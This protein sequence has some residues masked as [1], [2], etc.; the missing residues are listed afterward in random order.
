MISIRTSRIF[1]GVAAALV[2][3]SLV[4]VA[5]SGARADGLS[6]TFGNGGN[7]QFDGGGFAVGQG[8]G[9]EGLPLP[10]K[11]RQSDDDEGLPLP[12]IVPHVQV[13]VVIAG[14]TDPCERIVHVGPSGP[15][16]EDQ[17]VREM[18]TALGYK[19][20]LPRARFALLTLWLAHV[21]LQKHYKFMDKVKEDKTC[22]MSQYGDERERDIRKEI[23]YW[24]D[25]VRGYYHG[26][27]K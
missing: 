22:G 6:L 17:A 5:I 7:M 20:V 23:K 21:D 8:M 12:K 4:L 3:T 13:D 9:D 2:A 27:Y 14:D 16:S 25:R 15:V 19:T 11:H 18:A 24:E 1:T 26:T 10:R